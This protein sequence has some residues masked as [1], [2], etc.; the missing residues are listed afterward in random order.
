MLPDANG[1][2][3]TR[4]SDM[5]NNPVVNEAVK[6]VDETVSRVDR[7]GGAI[8]SATHHEVRSAAALRSVLRS[9]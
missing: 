9:R 3:V 8:L 6:A 7:I 1:R 2:V 4:G 5:K